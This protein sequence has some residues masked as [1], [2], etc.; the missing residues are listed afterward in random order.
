MIEATITDLAFGG[1][2][3]VRI[4]GMAVFVDPAVPGDQ[5][6]ARIIKKRKNY[7]EARVVEILTPSA[8]RVP[9]L[10]ITAAGAVDVKA[11]SSITI[12]SLFISN[13]RWPIPSCISG[14]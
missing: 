3:L 7:A 8:D 12:N 4:D 10:A 1:R 9:P 6:R 2:G 11:N 13:N 14:Q 5:I